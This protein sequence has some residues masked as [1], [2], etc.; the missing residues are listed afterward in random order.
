MSLL[1]IF[2]WIVLIVLVAS[3]L[4]VIVIA[5]MLPGRIARGRG[6]PWASAVSMAGWVGLLSSC[7]GRWR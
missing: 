5:G 4:G 3:T 7:Y 6:H 2:A 1:D